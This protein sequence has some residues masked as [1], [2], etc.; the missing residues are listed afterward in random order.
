MSTNDEEDIDDAPLAVKLEAL[1]LKEYDEDAAA[2]CP[3]RA[4][5][6]KGC[7]VVLGGGRRAPS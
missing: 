3:R 1:L 5:N 6:G 4:N 7:Q 2:V